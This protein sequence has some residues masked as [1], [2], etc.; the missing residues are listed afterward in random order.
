MR[1]LCVGKPVV[2]SKNPAAAVAAVNCAPCA[3]SYFILKQKMLML[4]DMVLNEVNK[5]EIPGREQM[6]R[7]R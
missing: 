3:N 4:H 5:D 6:A 1:F 7:N 2:N